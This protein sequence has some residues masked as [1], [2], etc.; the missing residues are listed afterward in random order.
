MLSFKDYKVKSNEYPTT[1][2]YR[3]YSPQLPESPFHSI[4][5]RS[6]PYVLSAPYSSLPALRWLSGV[7]LTGFSRPRPGNTHQPFIY[8][9][10][11]Y[12]FR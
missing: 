4:H 7:T 1:K 2:K 8:G 11:I 6:L 9:D 10:F 12:S 5:I 3:R